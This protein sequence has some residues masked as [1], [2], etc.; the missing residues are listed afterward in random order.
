MR[1][2]A[3]PLLLV[4]FASAPARAQAPKVVHETWHAAYFEGVRAG[5]VHTRVEQFAHDGATFYRA[6]RALHLTLRR[7]NSVVA[8]RIE[9]GSE[10]GADG[11][12]TAVSLTQITDKGGRF[13]TTGTVEDGKLRV[14]S[15]RDAR[16]QLVPWN[17][18]VLGTYKQDLL[19]KERKVK[20]GDKLAF[21]TYEM[22]VLA[23]LTIRAVVK[24]A[25]K[26]DVLQAS[27]VDGKVTVKRVPVKLLRVESVADKITVGENTIRLP[28]QLAWLDKDRMPVRYQWEFPGL[29]LITLYET[30]KEVATRPG[31]APEQ[32]PDLGLNSIIG[33][34]KVVERPYA[35][36]G[37][38]YRI[39]VKDDDEPGTLF[40]R[41]G[42]QEVKKLKKSTFELHVKAEAEKTKAG[43][44]GKEFLESSHFLDCD[45]FLIKGWAKKLAKGEEEDLAKARRMEKWVHDTM[46]P[47]NG[48]G[49]A[50]ASQVMMDRTGD[51]RQHAMLLAALCR[52]A[53]VPARTAVGLV[54]VRQPGGRPELI[55]HMWTEVWSDG[56][57]VGL[58]ATLG[59][60]GISACHVKVA[61][62]SWRDVRTLAPLLPVARVIG[63]V[64]VEVVE[65]R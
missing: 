36:R 59:R 58:D 31:L 16:G 39:T 17:A 12:A 35:T 13:T 18:A 26:V 3:L 29:G 24:E 15:P 33:V 19:Y 53:N 64:Q 46:K 22:S 14:R 65:T 45:N 56:R 1:R 30:T 43:A 55:F 20:P 5:H 44:P 63:K 60:G 51:C 50:T 37:A 9:V 21:V 52:A 32:L 6:T 40:A 8:L 61:D 62:S 57:W 48:I 47:S 23:P 38:V 42:R 27:K 11:K 54:Y 10:E 28:R 7:Y 25:E 49:L 2:Y 41:D 4:L 34:A